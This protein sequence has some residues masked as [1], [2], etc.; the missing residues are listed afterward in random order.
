[1]TQPTSTA[2]PHNVPVRLSESGFEW[3]EALR[4]EFDLSRADVIRESLV[5]AA[6]HRAQV[7]TRLAD[8]ATGF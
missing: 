8:L 6:N 3:V 4:K 1:M 7:E 5:V 2:R